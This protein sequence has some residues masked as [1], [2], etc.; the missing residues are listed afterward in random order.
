MKFKD[1]S[2]PALMNYQNDIQYAADQ[3]SIPA[4]LLAAIVLRESG[5]QNIYQIGMAHGPGCGVGL[6]QITAGVDWS[7][8]NDPTFQGYHLMTPA[9]NLYVSANFFLKGL[10]QSA[11]SAEQ[12]NSAAFKASCR[13][14]IVFAVA[15]GYNAGWGAVQSA[16]AQGVD[17]DTKTT[18]GYGADVLAKYVALVNASH[19]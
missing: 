15:C 12:N 19:A 18:N 10:V 11:T 5:G 3:A 14:E 17:A 4:C 16:M 2:H 8:P 13:N 6:T 7:N 1:P 9:D